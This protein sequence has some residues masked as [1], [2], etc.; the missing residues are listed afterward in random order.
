MTLTGCSES[1]F[2]CSDGRCVSIDVRCDGKVDCSDGTDE[3]DCKAFITFSGYN[4]FLVPPPV[5]NESTLTMNISL[6]IDEIITINEKDGYFKIKMTLVR[7]WFNTQLTYQNLKR[8]WVKNAMSTEDI[9]RMWKPWTV[10]DNIENV[11]EL[12]ITDKA[13]IM[14]IIPNTGYEYERADRTNIQTA[15]LFRGSKNAISYQRQATVNWMCDYNM[16]WYPFDSQTC[17]L[18]M[19][20]IEASITLL[21]SFVN[22]SGAKE[23]TQHFVKDVRMCSFTIEERSG[24]VVEVTLSRPLFGTILSVFMPTGIMIVLSQ[25]VRVFYRDYLDMVIQVNLTLLLVLATL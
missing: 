12:K 6:N 14:T 7:N 2:T 8:N 22:Y 5:G 24:V 16:R 10:L 11:D 15:R 18:K 3:D 17:K 13:D 23:L 4:K 9:D 1:E 21:P 25:L 19:F 20:H